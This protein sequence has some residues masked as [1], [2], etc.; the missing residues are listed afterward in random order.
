MFAVVPKSGGF[1]THVSGGKLWI[2]KGYVSHPGTQ[3]NEYNFRAYDR[4]KPEARPRL[5]QLAL[6]YIAALQG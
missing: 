1:K 5:R 6:R 2:G 4:W 3:P